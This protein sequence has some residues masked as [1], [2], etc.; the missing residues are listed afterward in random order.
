MPSRVLSIPI[1]LGF[2]K[3]LWSRDSAAI[4]RPCHSAVV[5]EK[6]GRYKK[7][8]RDGLNSFSG[9]FWGLGSAAN[10]G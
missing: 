4:A 3:S 10:L 7:D 9:E 5:K 8:K 6:Q 2:V 1:S